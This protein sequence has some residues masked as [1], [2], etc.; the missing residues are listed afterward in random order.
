MF[1]VEF[2]QF[3]LLSWAIILFLIWYIIIV[4][5]IIPKHY[6]VMRSRVEGERVSKLILWDDVIHE[7]IDEVKESKILERILFMIPFAKRV[8]GS[9]LEKKEMILFR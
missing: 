9:F 7:D 8:F 4:A 3:L 1:K 6:K 5:V 2:N